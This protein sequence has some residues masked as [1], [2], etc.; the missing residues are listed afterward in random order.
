METSGGKEVAEKTYINSGANIQLDTYRYGEYRTSSLHKYFV[1]NKRVHRYLGMGN[2]G[3]K[4]N[5]ILRN[6]Y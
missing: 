6:A 1:R 4:K 2:I 3:V 5:P